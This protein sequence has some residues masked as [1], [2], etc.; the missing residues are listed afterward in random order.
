M[1]MKESSERCN[2]ADLEDGKRGHKLRN[3]GGL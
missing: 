3:A 2:T 1:I